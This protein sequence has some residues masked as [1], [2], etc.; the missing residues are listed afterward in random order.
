MK[1]SPNDQIIQD[2]MKPGILTGEGFLGS[3]KRSFREIIAEDM[4]IVSKLPH[5]LE[6]IAM[7]MVYFM[8]ESFLSYDGPIVIDEHY[9]VEHKTYRGVLLSPF[10]Q[11]GRFGKATI[12]LT[13]LKNNSSIT[14]TP[15]HI[16]FIR[17]HGFFQGK[18]SAFRLDPVVLHKTL[19]E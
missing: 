4:K 11:A 19:F 15:L 3:D 5:S 14:W 9:K 18:G 16:H 1:L 12:K 6:E 13:N 17:D 7:R 10:P 2:K 8:D